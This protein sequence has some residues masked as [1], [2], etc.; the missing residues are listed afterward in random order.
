[1]TV[2]HAAGLV[3]TLVAGFKL[4]RGYFEIK[5]LGGLDNFEVF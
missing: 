4:Q 2:L 5:R 1:M 3:V